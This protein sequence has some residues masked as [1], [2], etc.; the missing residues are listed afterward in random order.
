MKPR[1]VLLE[2]WAEILAGKGDSSAI[3]D[4]AGKVVRTFQQIDDRAG[5][6][7]T[8]IANFQPGSVLAVQIGNHED[9]LSILIACLRRNVVVLPL[10]TSISEQQR[11]AAL[12]I[13]RAGGIIENSATFRSIDSQPPSWPGHMPS[14]L[15]L[16]SGTT[17]APRAIRFRSEQLLA[18]CDQICE[19]KGISDL[20]L[21]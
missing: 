2:R 17:A 15:K 7:A 21:N 12:K 5:V 16:T 18:D 10:E 1:D 8:K 20:D 9:W 4:T 19:T 3:F 13:C 11:E 6:F 14:L